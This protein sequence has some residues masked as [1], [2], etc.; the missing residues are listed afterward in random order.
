LMNLLGL[1]PIKMLIY[2]A[3]LY[4]LIAPILILIILH[5]CNNRSILKRY[6]NGWL[7]NVFGIMTF[8]VMAAVAILFLYL[9]FA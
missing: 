8:I 1:S 5:I 3:V 2:S 6:V 7:S 4:G 9:Q